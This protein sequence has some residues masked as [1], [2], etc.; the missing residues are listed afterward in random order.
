MKK[1]YDKINSIKFLKNIKGY[2]NLLNLKIKNLFIT[3]CD[4]K[5]HFLFYYKM[6]RK[7]IKLFS[8]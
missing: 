7:L 4:E 6:N 3:Y 2:R 5:H 8:C 1:T